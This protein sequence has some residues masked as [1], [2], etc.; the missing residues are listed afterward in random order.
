MKI[1]IALSTFL[2]LSISAQRSLSPVTFFVM[3]QF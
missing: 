1:A 3:I 2:G